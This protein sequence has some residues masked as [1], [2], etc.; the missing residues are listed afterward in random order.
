MLSAWHGVE[1]SEKE[2]SWNF[3][4]AN[5]LVITPNGIKFK[6]Q[7]FDVTI[8]SET[9]LYDI[10]YSENLRDKIVIQAGGFIGDTALYYAEK[11]AKVFSF[12]PDPN[13][14]KLALE[15]IKLNPQFSDNI[16]MRNYALGKDEL[17][18]F[19]VNEAG[20]GGSSAFNI[21]KNKTVKVKSVSIAQILEEF[22]IDSP[23]LLDLDVKGKEFEIINDNS[24]A[25][26]Y[27][28]RIEYTTS[29]LGIVVN[30]RDL[31]LNSLKD[32]GFTS[33]RVFKHNGGVY[34]L[35]NH[36]TIECSKL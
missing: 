27:K 34:D 6:L 11:G 2:G 8:F 29:Y 4:S 24:L 28:V 26:F 13:S 7:G 25:K 33:K 12:E 35:H 36:G 16:V 9:F 32:Y 21:G 15:N 19:P 1:F 3:D 14:Y 23:Y 30:G 31:L 10:H 18:D 20:S 17:I 5:N 22:H